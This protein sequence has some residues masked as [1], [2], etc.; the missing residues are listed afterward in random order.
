[1]FS[2]R[3]FTV[4]ISLFFKNRLRLLVHRIYGRL[5]NDII[6]FSG[7]MNIVFQHLPTDVKLTTIYRFFL[8]IGIGNISGLWKYIWSCR[9]P[10]GLPG[11]RL[12]KQE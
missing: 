5:H 7:V 2:N 10:I 3:L 4:I 6:I 9:L 8:H 12:E 1:M 11:P